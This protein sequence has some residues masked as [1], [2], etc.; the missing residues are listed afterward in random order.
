MEIYITHIDT[1]CLILDIGGFRIMT[2][3]T[4]DKA[5]GLYHH[6]FGAISRKTGNPALA[7]GEYQDVDLIL[8][9]HHQHKDNLDTAGRKFLSTVKNVVSTVDAARAIPG[10]KGLKVWESWLLTNVKIRNLRITATPAQHR[11]SW[12]PGFVSGHVIGFI[13]EFDGQKGGAIYISGDTVFFKGIHEIAR[14]F[15]IRTAIFNVGAVQFRYL[16]GLGRYTMNGKELI[17]AA[18]ILKPE[19]IYPVHTSGWSHFKEN[20]DE[21]RLVLSDDPFTSGR[22]HFLRPGERTR[23]ALPEDADY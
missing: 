21:L 23:V 11:P 8:L 9:S 6:G 16:T 7:P 14:R 3:P 10:I 2:D 15:S 18:K 4:L 13:I 19:L 22:T 12:V 17:E 20:D 1:A 5:G